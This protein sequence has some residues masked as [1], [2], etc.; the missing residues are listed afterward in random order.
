MRDVEELKE[1]LAPGVG[2]G[3]GVIEMLVEEEELCE[4][5]G[6][7]EGLAELLGVRDEEA[8]AVAV[9]LWEGV[10]ESD[11][12]HVSIKGKQVAHSFPPRLGQGSPGWFAHPSLPQ[13]YCVL[14]LPFVLEGQSTSQLVQSSPRR[15]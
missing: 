6:V 13:Q 10:V 11:A 15:G 1:G 4:A 9:K 7:K 14:G 12:L 8:D 2:V 5:L 3:D